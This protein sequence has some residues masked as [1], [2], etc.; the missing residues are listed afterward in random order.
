MSYRTVVH[1]TTG[2]TPAKL[3]LGRNLRVP[4]DL[5]YPQPEG[6]SIE[7]RTQYAENLHEKLDQVQSFARTHLKVA[8][9]RMKLYY[10]TGNENK[11][12]RGDLVWLYSPQRKKGISPKLMRPWKGPFTVT[13]RLNDLVYRIQLGPRTKPKVVHHNRLWKYRGKDHP[14]WLV[15]LDATKSSHQTSERET[16]PVSGQDVETSPSH[17]AEEPEMVSDSS[18][19]TSDTPEENVHS[20]HMPGV[21]ENSG[22][23]RSRRQHRPPDRY[24][25][26]V[27]RDV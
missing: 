18:N 12:S 8:S 25:H 21:T 1:S 5:L 23:R 10:D 6:E 3:M 9:D 20:F 4:V 22:L 11:F 26:F 7:S 14:R 13:K 15:E 19:E 2:C 24:G 17:V 16:R 27:T